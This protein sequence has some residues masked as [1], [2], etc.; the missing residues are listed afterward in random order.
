MHAGWM[1]IIGNMIFLW[2]F[3]PQIEDSN[4][5]FQ[6]EVW[7]PTPE[8]DD[9]VRKSSGTS[10]DP[11]DQIRPAFFQFGDPGLNLPVRHIRDRLDPKSKSQ[12]PVD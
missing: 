9:I 6:I 10:A 3:G 5:R 2:A 11:L 1:H 7:R 4:P 8:L 12:R